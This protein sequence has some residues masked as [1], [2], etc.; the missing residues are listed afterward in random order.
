[1]FYKLSIDKLNSC[2]NEENYS[3]KN[4]C[5][6]VCFFNIFF[7]IFL[8]FSLNF[9]A[10]SNEAEDFVNSVSNRA[11]DIISTNSHS[12]ARSELGALFESSV[13]ITWISKFILG[14]Y[15]QQFSTEEFGK[16]QVLYKSYLMRKYVPR[17]KEFSGYESVI[18]YSKSLG[19]NYYLVQTK[20]FD[21]SKAKPLTVEYRV[22]KASNSR[23]YIHDITVDG[24][25]LILTHRSDFTNFLHTNSIS[26]LLQDL[27]N[28]TL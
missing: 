6:K 28:K 26:N 20:V 14:K 8:A 23:F 17:F 18:N 24:I 15:Y 16:F 5:H 19:K 11:L 7:A 4:N 10:Y 2:N 22:K 3:T 25:S 12:A 27:E 1:M 21:P 9:K 13:N